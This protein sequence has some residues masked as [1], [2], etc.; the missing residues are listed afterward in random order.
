M[1]GAELRPVTAACARV[2]GKKATRAAVDAVAGDVALSTL[3][4]DHGIEAALVLSR[5][6]QEL[7]Q[8]D[9]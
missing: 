7:L 9:G 6:L 2:F 8:T 4:N 1:N 5:Y 3:S